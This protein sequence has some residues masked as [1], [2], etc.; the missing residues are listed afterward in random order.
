MGSEGKSSANPAFGREDFVK[1]RYGRLVQQHRR[2]L[3]ISPAELASAIGCSKYTIENIESGASESGIVRHRALCD[4]F[5]M[6][7][8]Q[9]T[10]SLFGMECTA[11]PLEDAASI[12][13]NDVTKAVCN[14]AGVFAAKSSTDGKIK[15]H[16][17]LPEVFGALNQALHILSLAKC[18]IKNEFPGAMQ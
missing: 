4:V 1:R 3:D 7:F 13:A 10:A 12:T 5:G 2:R 14:V 6:A 17:A 15:D 16:T 8:F 9:D 18:A 11:L